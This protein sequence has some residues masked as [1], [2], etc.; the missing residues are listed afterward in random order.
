MGFLLVAIG[1]ALGSFSRYQLGSYI[2][3]KYQR[4]FPVG[5][6]FIN[7]TGAFLLGVLSSITMSKG[8]ELFFFD[9]F[10]AAYTTFSTFMAE[11]VQLIENG[12]RV[13]SIL[14]IFTSILF[15]VMAYIVGVAI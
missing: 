11:S 12:F 6:F 15:G 5:T 14:Y 7:L 10:L 3:K 1:G 2:T 9:G 4:K 8:A 13:K